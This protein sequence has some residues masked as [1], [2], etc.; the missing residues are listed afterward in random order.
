MRSE[1]RKRVQFMPGSMP[2]TNTNTELPDVLGMITGGLRLNIGILQ[3][4]FAISPRNTVV[5]QPFEALLLLQSAADKPIQ[6]NATLR[7]PKKDNA[8]NKI[9]LWLPKD[10]A[11]ITLQPA[12]TGLLHMPIVSRPPT[13]PGTES[14]VALKVDV[15]FPRNIRMVRPPSG[16]R[17]ASVLSISPFR[18]NILREV[19]FRIAQQEEHVLTDTFEIVPGVIS[20]A[21]P[22]NAPRYESLWTPRDLASEQ[23]H[24]AELEQS[25]EQF[26]ATI[27]RYAV[28]EPLIELVEQRFLKVGLPLHS[29]EALLIA[30]SIT[31]VLEDG[32][33]LHPGFSLYASR[34]FKQLVGMIEDPAT[35]KDIDK[36]IVRLFPSLIFD[37]VLLGLTLVGE[38]SK[39]SLGSPNEQIEYASE[40]VAAIEGNIPIDLGHAYLPLVLAGILLNY[41]IKGMRENPWITLHEISRAWQ[42][43]LSNAENQFEWVARVFNGFVRKAEK[44]LEEAR[45]DRPTKF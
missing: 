4:A 11:Q 42:G 5:G 39:S 22:P 18:I 17:P 21:P 40:V 27:T 44:D 34:W 13:Q 16:G 43:R 8:G 7:L 45:I 38:E 35:T 32:L 31:Y 25:A 26:A 23:A 1:Q 14:A 28:L 37:S 2:P 15:K 29:S 6:V 41:R 19:G 24:Y 33:D 30:K 3:C 12:E 9:N 10:S 36:L 20:A